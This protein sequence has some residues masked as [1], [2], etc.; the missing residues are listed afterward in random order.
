MKAMRLK[1]NGLATAQIGR[2]KCPAFSKGICWKMPTVPALLIKW[3]RA[4]LTLVLLIAGTGIPALSQTARQELEAAIAL[5]N[6]TYSH[7]AWCR[8]VVAYGSIATERE[9]QQILSEMVDAQNVWMLSGEV[10]QPET[11]SLQR[12][13]DYPELVQSEEYRVYV[14]RV[15]SLVDQASLWFRVEWE[16]PNDT[17]I[18]TLVVADEQHCL[19]NSILSESFYLVSYGLRCLHAEAR[20][21]F[22]FGWKVGEVIVELT[23]ICDPNTGCLINCAHSCIAWVSIGVVERNRCSVTSAQDCC[24]LNYDIVVRGGLWVRIFGVPIGI[25]STF[26]A[27]GSCTAC[28]RCRTRTAPRP[29]NPSRV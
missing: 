13:S 17:C 18:Q 28:C 3:N 12:A 16:L 26:S 15:R 20:N 4:L 1:S 24:I 29:L 9:R 8:G 27:N 7:V 21:F 23:A 14:D 2:D 11:L 5:W 22:G 10:S 19:Y 6:Q 25:G